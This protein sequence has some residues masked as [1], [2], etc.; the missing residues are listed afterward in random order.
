[1]LIIDDKGVTVPN[2]DDVVDELSDGY[3]SIYGQDINIA[4]DSPDG[5]RIGIEAQARKDSYDTLAYAIQMH[6]PQYAQGKWADIIAKLTGIKR[7][8][9]KYTLLPDVKITTDRNVQLQAGYVVRDTN[10]NNWILDNITMLYNGQTLVDFR[11]EFFG[12]VSLPVDSSLDPNQIITGVKSIQTTK[13]PIEGCLG[14]ST[15]SLMQRRERKLAINN[16]HD[17][18]GIEASLIDIDG[19]IDALVLENNT[20]VTDSNEV[21]AHSINAIVLGGSD[22]DIATIILKKIIGG[23]CGT[24]GSESYTVLGYRGQDRV[25][26]F[27][28]ATTKD[29]NVVVTLIRAHA[30]T[31]IDIDKIKDAIV[32]KKFRIGQDAVAGMLYCFE[33]DG[34]IYVKS[35]K[36]DGGDVSAVGIRQIANIPRENITVNI[37]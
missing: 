30:Q 16:T 2:L 1:M 32:A 28:R 24:Y 34:T 31:D 29:I 20:N 11:S 27:D 26:N 4:P 18:D 37:E 33:N 35:I 10:G 17:R 9:G 12:A 13:A 19:V 36:V 3:R 8:S 5:Q 25:I 21:P 7:E 6:D 23:G 22:E 14:E 15:A